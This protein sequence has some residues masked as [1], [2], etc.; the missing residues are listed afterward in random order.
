MKITKVFEKKEKTFSF[1]IFPPKTPEG[2][3]KLIHETLKEFSLLKPDFVSCTYGAAGGNKDKTLALVEHIQKAYDI[4]SM[5]HLS[6]IT[7]TKDEIHEIVKKIKAKGIQN[8]LALRGDPPRDNPDMVPGIDNYKHSSELITFLK[9]EY[10]DDFC[11]GV[12]GFPEIHPLSETKEIDIKYL[13]HKIDCGAD[14]IITQLFFDNQIYFDYVESA[15]KE[16]I[17]ARIIPGILPITSYDG[18]IKFC[19]TCGAT[20]PEKIHKIFAPI[21][22][23]PEQVVKAGISFAVE[24]CLELIKNGAPGIHF[25]TLNKIHPIKEIVEIVR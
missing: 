1:E 6:C 23:N 12:A 4:P 7:H 16:G 19:N 21:K 15:R 9:Q 17:T 14:F 10:K 22:D 20:I 11:L 5:A 13:K 8:I 24:Q 25:Y 3:I 2:D 18:L